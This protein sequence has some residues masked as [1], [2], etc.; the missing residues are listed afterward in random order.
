MN[1][2]KSK[3]SITIKVDFNDIRN[4]MNGE[5]SD[6]EVKEKCKKFLKI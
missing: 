6:D 5:V 1:I 3:S 2:S 4:L